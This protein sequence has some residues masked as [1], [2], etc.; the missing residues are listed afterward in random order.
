ML[1]QTVSLHFAGDSQAGTLTHAK[2]RCQKADEMEVPVAMFVTR[3]GKHSYGGSKLKR[4]SQRENTGI[5]GLMVIW[6]C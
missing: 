3:Q 6:S 4:E 5:T 1:A 2:T